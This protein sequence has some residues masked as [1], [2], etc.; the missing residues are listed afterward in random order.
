[1]DQASPTTSLPNA[2]PVPNRGTGGST[3]ATAVV[4][5]VI[6]GFVGCAIL[7]S[8]IALYLRRQRRCAIERDASANDQFIVH[9]YSSSIPIANS[10][11]Q[12][13]HELVVIWDEIDRLRRLLAEISDGGHSEGWEA[14]PSYNSEVIPQERNRLRSTQDEEYRYRCN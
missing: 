8:L 10:S 3:P 11:E 6:G 13:M 7:I 12:M 5:G 9:P 1:M 4:S 14:P 2:T